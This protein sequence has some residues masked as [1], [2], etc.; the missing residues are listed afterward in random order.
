MA[1]K[2]SYP[3]V[4]VIGA[5][6]AGCEAVYQL[7]RRGIPVTLYEMR[8]EVE[9][10]AHQTDLLAE[11]VCSNSI[12]SNLPDRASGM[13]KEEL[14]SFGSYILDV[15]YKYRVPA[16]N[17]LAVDRYAF[18]REITRYIRNHSLVRFMNEEAESFPSDGYVILASGP[19]TSKKLM[20]Y[21][22]EV[23]GAKHLSFFDAIAP[24]VKAETIDMSIAFR[25]DRYGGEGRGDYLNCPFTREQ[26]LTFVQELLDAEKIKLPAFEKKAKVEFFSACQPVEQIASTGVDSLRF[27]PMKPVGL[28]DPRTGQR[29]YAAV[30]LR[31]DNLL[32]NLF[33]LVGFQTNLRHAEQ[34]RVFRLIPG[35]AEAEFVR[36]GQL[37]RN[38]YLDAPAFLT[39]TM[40]VE[41][42][43]NWF[44][45]GQICGV[46]GYTESA[47]TGLPAGYNLARIMLG[48]EPV[49]PPPETMLGALLQYVT[50]KGHKKFAPMN[51]NFGL[52]PEMKGVKGDARKEQ[53]VRTARKAF[54][55]FFKDI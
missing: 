29:P 21:L 44:I 24:I 39:P 5:G 2:P 35:L 12:G 47:A 26:Y 42:H 14:R 48:K 13:L 18:S 37:H 40:Q 34:E 8:P 19:L 41:G 38:S 4:T 9:T 53:I 43:P 49:V 51:A 3:P 20:D 33:N 25:A 46:E 10:G 28:A 36:F 50:F 54:R 55:E 6:L 52:F 27:G 7:V 11:L 30:Q 22:T 15:A 32:A 31:Q 45:G 23:F 16:G 17:A 1:K